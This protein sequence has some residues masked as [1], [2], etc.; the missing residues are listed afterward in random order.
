[1]QHQQILIAADQC[2]RLG[3]QREGKKFGVVGIAAGWQHS[4]YVGIL[5]Y[6]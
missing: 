4:L 5:D 6:I 3:G 1:M 2:I